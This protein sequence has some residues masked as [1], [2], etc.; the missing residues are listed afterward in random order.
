MPLPLPPVAKSDVAEPG[1][2]RQKIEGRLRDKFGADFELAVFEYRGETTVYVA[3]ENLVEVARFLRDDSALDFDMMA[4]CTAVDWMLHKHS[5][6]F[7]VAYNLFS[8][9]LH[10]RMRLKAAVP[11]D[12]CWSHS[13]WSVWPSCN[14]MEREAYD[15][16]GIIYRGHPDL[17]RILM[18]DDWQGHPLRKDFPLG[19]V[20]SFYYKRDS[21]PH[22]GEPE[23]FIPRIRVQE[24]DV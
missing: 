15:M 11:A 5:P 9:R 1:P 19:G 24:G 10:H 12:D 14:F 2:L 7:E 3:R 21:D 13:L 4:Y 17:R 6:R 16:F 22:A 8:T 23:G 18:P 20:K